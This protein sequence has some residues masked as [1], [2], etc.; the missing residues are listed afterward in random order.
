LLAGSTTC[1]CGCT[2]N[3]PVRAGIES[4][5]PVPESAAMKRPSMLLSLE[6][7]LAFKIVESGHADLESAA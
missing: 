2:A 4:I 3:I 6:I 7:E 1:I 5:E